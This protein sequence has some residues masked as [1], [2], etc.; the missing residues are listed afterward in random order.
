MISSQGSAATP[1]IVRAARSTSS[2]RSTTRSVVSAP[3]ASTC[4]TSTTT[5]S[6][7]RSKSAS[8]RST[9]SSPPARSA[10]SGPPTSRPSDSSRPVCSPRTG[11]PIQGAHDEVQPPRAA[12]VRG[13]ARTRGARPGA[14]GAA[15][16]RAGERLPR[17]RRA[18]AL[19][20]PARRPR[21]TAGR[22]SQPARPPGARSGRPIAF[23]HGVPPATIALAWLLAKPTVVAPVVSATRPEQ[24][25]ALIGAAS[26]EL[27]R[28]ELVELDRASA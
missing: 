15:V 6:T 1:N 3:I 10:Q 8:A 2:Q 5:T 24:V 4:C 23:S 12:T 28:S 11:C 26:I 19:R 9:R 22:P 25:E 7:P 21:G 16:L 27:Q 13:C 14:R 17:G 18:A 20:R